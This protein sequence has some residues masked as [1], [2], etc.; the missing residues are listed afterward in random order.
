M[1]VLVLIGFVMAENVCKEVNCGRGTCKASG[2]GTFSFE[3]DCDSGWK[4]TLSD[5]DDGDNH[6]KF[7]PC[8]IPKC[9]VPSFSLSYEAFE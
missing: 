6:F 1:F 8:I 3:C 4:Q 7:L 2:N 9:Q 5:D